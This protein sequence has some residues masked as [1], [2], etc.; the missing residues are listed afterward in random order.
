MAPRCGTLHRPSPPE[1]TPARGAREPVRP[2]GRRRPRRGPPL[3][4][5]RP[6]AGSDGPLLVGQLRC[7]PAGR[8]TGLAP[9]PRVSALGAGARGDVAALRPPGAR[10][11]AADQAT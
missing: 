11:L 4:V 6:A 5:A 1:G 2:D 3:P 9:P 7:R 10:A 8:G